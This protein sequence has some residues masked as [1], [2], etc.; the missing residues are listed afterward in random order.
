M[1]P[2]PERAAAI[3]DMKRPGMLQDV[4][5]F[6]GLTVMIKPL[7]TI[8]KKGVKFGEVLLSWPSLL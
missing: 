6:L 8:T 3:T 5:H 2:N 7:T 1:R 4:S